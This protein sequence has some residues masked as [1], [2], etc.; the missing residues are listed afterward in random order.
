M[1]PATLDEVPVTIWDARLPRQP[2]PGTNHLHELHMSL[3]QSAIE[4][5]LLWSQAHI[6]EHSKR[7]DVR[8]QPVNTVFIII[9]KLWTRE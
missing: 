6:H 8:R 5:T 3:N 2:A 1:A 7:I 4:L 9:I